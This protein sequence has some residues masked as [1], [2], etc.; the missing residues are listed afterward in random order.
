MHLTSTT[1][2]STTSRYA[3]RATTYIVLHYLLSY[4]GYYGLLSTLVVALTAASF[5]GGQTAVLV[6]VFAL[7]N[8]VASIPLAPWLDRVPAAHSVLLGCVMAGAAFVSLRFAT[9]MSMTVISLGL[10]GVGIS[11]NALASKQLAAAASDRIEKRS[12]L[13]SLISIGVNIAAAVAAPLAL[14]LVER[15]QHGQVLLA[16]AAIYCIAGVTT[17][18][19]RATVQRGSHPART[20]SLDVYL[21]VLREPGLRAFLLINMFYWFL[22]GQLFNVLA[23]YVSETLNTPASLGWLY[24]LNALLV[25]VLQLVVT[26]LAD[27]WT[28]G[29]QL[30]TVVL[31]YALFA[32]SFLAACLVPGYGGAVVFVLLFT[33]AEMMFVPSG[34]V[35]IVR[36]IRQQNRAVG[37]SIFAVSTALGEAF[38]GGAGIVSYRWLTAHGYGNQ[39]WFAAA[40]LA[41]AFALIT[42]RLRRSSPGLRSLTSS[43]A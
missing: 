6:M 36:L 7:T 32:L 5:N 3:R 34:D 28:G 13:F 11:I 33:V 8:K 12:Q 24:T 20:W 27:R 1:A 14:L 22:Y 30:T 43:V 40:G 19:N 25:V 26:R 35:L 41:L 37:Y 16:V 42:Q 18:L 2:A 39:F 4:L 15:K 23:V 10:A 17:F 9:G 38:G 21:A 29:R 31:S